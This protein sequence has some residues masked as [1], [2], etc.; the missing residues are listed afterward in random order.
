MQSTMRTQSTLKWTSI[1]FENLLLIKS[2]VFNISRRMIN[3][4]TC[5]Q[6]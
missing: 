6:K 4:Q 2:L 5:L 3:W 1:I